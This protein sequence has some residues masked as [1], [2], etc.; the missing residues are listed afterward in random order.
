MRFRRN[1]YGNKRCEWQGEKFQSEKELDRYKELLL[2]Q[3]ARKINNL[4]RQVRFELTPNMHID[5]EFI[6]KSEYIADFTY[7]E[8]GKFIIE[9]C[10]GFQTDV[11]KLKK[12]MI[13]DKYGY[14]IRE[15]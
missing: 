8:N 5:G 3:R 9:D 7:W 11:Y 2:L 1:K 14:L 15:T 4:S 12:K 10:K 13:A 6:R